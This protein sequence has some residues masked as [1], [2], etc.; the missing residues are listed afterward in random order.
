MLFRSDRATI[1]KRAFP[2]WRMGYQ[3]LKQPEPANG[4][5][6]TYLGDGDLGQQADTLPSHVRH[7]IELFRDNMR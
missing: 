2:D 3:R 6:S 4:G 5:M 1:A 7:L